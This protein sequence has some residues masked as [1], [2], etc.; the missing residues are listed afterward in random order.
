VPII[1]LRRVEEIYPS[2]LRESV[3]SA[4]CRERKVFILF[5]GFMWPKKIKIFLGSLCWI[6]DLP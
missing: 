4:L 5:T 3:V 2:V 6:F 1:K